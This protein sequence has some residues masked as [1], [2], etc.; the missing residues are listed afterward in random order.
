M[1]FDCFLKSSKGLEQWQGQIS[2]LKNYGSHYEM[3][4]ESL[5][6]I[7]VLFGKTSLGNF[8]CMPDFLAGCHLGEFDNEN[9]NKDKLMQVINPIDAVTIANALK[10]FA[11]LK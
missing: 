5:S 1:T 2:N 8:A 3:R 10:L 11:T 4:I 9:Y 6:G 7:T